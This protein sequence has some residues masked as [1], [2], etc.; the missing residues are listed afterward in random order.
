MKM[1]LKKK[2]MSLAVIGAM[3]AV[4]VA[5]AANIGFVNINQ[6]VSS[7]PGYGAIELQ[8]QAVEKN[9]KPKIEKEYNAINKLEESKREAAFNEKVVPLNQQAQSEINKI[10]NP[11]MTDIVGRIDTIRKGK[12]IDVVVDNPYAVISADAN[13]QVINIT[14]DVIATLKK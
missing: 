3:S 8:I 6:V 5:S 7:Y 12:S 14:N 11:M 2:V 13:S 1:N 4:A 9:Y 10:I